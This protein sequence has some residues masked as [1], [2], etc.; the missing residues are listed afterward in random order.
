MNT[1]P[2]KRLRTELG[3]TQSTAAS[4]AGVTEQVI[5]KTEQGLY[6]TM[7]PS[8]LYSFAELSGLSVGIIAAMYDDWI[9]EALLTVKLPQAVGLDE[10]YLNRFE[11][12]GWKTVVCRLNGVPDT[13]NSFCKLFKMNPYVIQKY[14]SG[15][16][17]QAPLQ[18]VE[19]VAFIKGE[20]E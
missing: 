18:L 14:E 15:K 3:M 11:F 12:H 9:N 2:I 7:P 6:P 16:L 10:A 8:V 5:L 20:L 4:I 19:R 17:K 1:N 13:V